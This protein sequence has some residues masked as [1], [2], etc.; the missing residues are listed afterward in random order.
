MIK[1][2][3]LTAL[4]LIAM[5]GLLPGCAAS[6]Y[7]SAQ[8][9][10][11]SD[12]FEEVNRAIFGFNTAIDHTLINPVIDGYR[13]VVPAPARKGVNNALNNLQ[14]PIS[15]AN[16]LLQGDLEGAGDVLFSAIVNTFVGFGG[17]FDIAGHEGYGHDTEDFGQTLAVWGIEHGPYI[18]VPF[19]G[20][21]TLRDGGG[22]LVDAFADPLR[23]YSRNIDEKHIY[24]NKVA[25]NYFNTRNNLKDALVE[26]EA[27]AI[28]YYA[29]VRSS[30]YQAREGKINDQGDDLLTT[31]VEVDFPEYDDF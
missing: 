10:G 11:M 18:V 24:Y 13:T 9:P 14:S 4:S 28:D 26:L 19:F 12:P 6:S 15:F 29:S 27:S 25:I 23:W 31:S 22:Y 5:A 7:D 3:I 20:P 17:L 1:N 21:T 8:T 2:R 30:Y 16:E